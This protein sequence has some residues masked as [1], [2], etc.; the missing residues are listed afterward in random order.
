MWLVGATVVDGTGRDP[1]ANGTVQ[2]ENG[3]ITRVGG[4]APPPGAD[5][6]DCSGM[7][8]TPGLIDAHTHLALSAD[9]HTMYAGQQSSAEIAADI[10][11]ISGQALDA[12]FT[13]VRDAGGADGGLASAIAGRKV[14]GPRVLPSG[15]PMVQTGGHGHFDPG[16][17]TAE[18]HAR[19]DM[20]GLRSAALLTDGPDAMRRNVRE[21][22]RR[23]AT[24][25][26]LC[27]S[28]GVVSTHDE[29][30]D[31]Q[32]SVEEIAVAVQEARARGSY[33]TVHAHNVAGIRNAVEAGVRCVEHGTQLDEATAAMMAEHDVALVPTLTVIHL[34]AANRTEMDELPSETAQR[35]SGLEGHQRETLE[36]ARAAGIRIGLGSDLIG[37][38]QD[39]RGLELVLR[40]Q[41]EEPMASLVSA[42]RDNAG[43]LGLGDRTGTL[44]SGKSADLVVFAGNPLEDPTLFNRPDEVA[45]VIQQGA[46]VKDLRSQI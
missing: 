37:P 34:L 1:V 35:A 3:S 22:F 19:G 12:G 42:T 38:K 18:N 17:V 4:D 41:I 31:T 10:F 40:A 7:T 28:G 23:G 44:E 14:R 25:I 45:L 11:A 16:W 32:L 15:P 24:Q 5:V 2:I 29:V 13:T 9:F 46:V 21:A 33:V 26:K 30:G 43:I 39:V 6:V 8:I 36:I 27:V 20:P